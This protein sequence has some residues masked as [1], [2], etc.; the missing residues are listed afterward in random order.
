MNKDTDKAIVKRVPFCLCT[1]TELEAGKT[2]GLSFCPNV[3]T[4]SEG[5]NVPRHPRLAEDG[6]AIGSVVIEEG[7]PDDRALEL[8]RAHALFA[9][10]A[11]AWMVP[12]I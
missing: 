5:E 10:D 6:E 9:Q 3:P 4:A 11:F 8:L 7:R 2:C 12:S 1:N